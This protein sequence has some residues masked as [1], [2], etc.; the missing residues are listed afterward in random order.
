[1]KWSRI[2]VGVLVII[3][4]I[5]MLLAYDFRNQIY[6][7]SMNIETNR[8][9]SIQLGDNLMH[10]LSDLQSKQLLEPHRN[11][12]PLHWYIAVYAYLNEMAPERMQAGEYQLE[13]N[14]KLYQFLDKVFSGQVVQRKFSIIEGYTMQQILAAM[15]AAPNINV[16]TTDYGDINRRLGIAESSPEGWIFPDTYY[17]TAGSDA[18]SILEQGYRKMQLVLAEAWQKRDSQL[19]LKS[20]YEALILA[21]IVE[22]ETSKLEERPQVAGVFI[23]R[24]VKKMR[25]QAD[26]TVIYGLG[27]RF[28]GNLRSRD[29][30]EDQ[31]YNSYIHKGLPPTPIAMP[32]LSSIEAVM[33]PEINDYL[34][35]VAKGDGS[36]YFSETYTEHLKAV[37]KYQL[38]Q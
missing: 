16:D 18:M 19:P 5:V 27:N 29:L 11:M 14:M 35:F 13:P 2:I 37:R 10:V 6:R 38:R 31:P 22:K 4:I 28:D 34:Y 26:P 36:H 20:P 21:S 30:K 33:N 3:V 32:S 7:K 8:N 25:L 15:E 1:M 12:V 24:L 9:F 23:A 17:Y